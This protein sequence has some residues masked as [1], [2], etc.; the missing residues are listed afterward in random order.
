MID[1]KICEVEAVNVKLLAVDD[2]HLPVIAHQVSSRPRHGDSI[3][4]KVFLQ[5]SEMFFATPVREGN[6]GVNEYATLHGVN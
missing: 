1:V 4:E 5:L 2:H 3:C 6:Q